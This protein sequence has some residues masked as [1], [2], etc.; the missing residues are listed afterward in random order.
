MLENWIFMAAFLGF[1]LIGLF[2]GCVLL[3][4]PGRYIPSY[5]WGQSSLR[6][7]RKPS[8]EIG[9]RIGG[10]LLSVMIIA[11]FARP[12]ILWMLH[13]VPSEVSWGESPLPKGMPRWDLLAVTIVAV[14]FG[15]LLLTRSEKSVELMFS[16]D[17]SRLQDK[18]TLRL[19]TLYVQTTAILIMTWSL[20]PAADF[21][22][23]L[24]P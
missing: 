24:R 3:I 13:P 9:K 21:I 20:L 19:W 5:T 10:L 17:K 8:F 14:V 18:I 16:A 23:S 22:R 4:A 2:H 6:L 1:S 11:I 12:A 15:F 7:S